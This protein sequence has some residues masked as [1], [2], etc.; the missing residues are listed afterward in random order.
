MNVFPIPARNSV[1]FSLAISGLEAP[2]R[3][4]LEIFDAK[5]AKIG[6][7]A[8]QNDLRRIGEHILQYDTSGLAPGT[9][10]YRIYAETATG[11]MFTGDDSLE[12]KFIIV[13]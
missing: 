1:S 13:N 3:I 4:Y 11:A 5:G 12:G 10:F 8:E 2:D 6:D 9:Y 7:L